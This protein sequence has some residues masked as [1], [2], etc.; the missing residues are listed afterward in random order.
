[1]CYI[2]IVLWCLTIGVLTAAVFK[3]DDLLGHVETLGQNLTKHI[4]YFHRNPIKCT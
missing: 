2:D 4:F 1:M 3:R